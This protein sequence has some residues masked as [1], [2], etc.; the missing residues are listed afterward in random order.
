MR[1]VQFWCAA[2]SAAAAGLVSAGRAGAVVISLSGLNNGVNNATDPEN[3]TTGQA[4]P[5]NYQPLLNA[6]PAPGGGFDG[7]NI[8]V[9]I[10]YTNSFVAAK[11]SNASVNEHT[12]MVTPADTANENLYDN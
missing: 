4:I 1:V 5:S 11:A 2:A 3:T 7:G 10:S 8:G 12:H 6:Y 9:T